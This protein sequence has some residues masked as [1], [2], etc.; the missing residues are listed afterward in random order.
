MDKKNMT[1]ETLKSTQNQE[2]ESHFLR[3]DFSMFVPLSLILVYI[4]FSVFYSVFK[5][6]LH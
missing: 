3:E 1:K 5:L 6:T 4:Y 2:F